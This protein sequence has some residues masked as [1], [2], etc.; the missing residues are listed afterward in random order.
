MCIG[1][2][3]CG[4]GAL[5]R[6]STALLHNHVK[7]VT[8]CNER[9]EKSRVTTSQGKDRMT[10]QTA[11]RPGRWSLGRWLTIAAALAMTT[12]W[13]AAD[14]FAADE[15]GVFSTS[16][17]TGNQLW[18]SEP[19]TITKTRL[20]AEGASSSYQAQVSPDS[21]RV[22]WVTA[23]G[24]GRS[25]AM[26]VRASD[27]KTAA[28]RVWATHTVGSVRYGM[29][30]HPTWSPDGAWLWYTAH[31]DGTTGTGTA[32]FKM[33]RDGTQRT[34]VVDWAND[35]SWPAISP[36]GR[37]IAFLSKTNPNGTLANNGDT[38][39]AIYTSDHLGQLFVANADGTAATQVTPPLSAYTR[40]NAIG[41]PAFSPDGTKIAFHAGYSGC[42]R[43]DYEIYTVPVTGAVDATPR[44]PR[45]AATSCTRPRAPAKRS[46]G[47][48]RTVRIR[49]R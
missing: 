25:D 39:G 13:P 14:A 42:C 15:I 30:S 49:G 21:E 8:L 24:T 6:S 4:R 28:T 22:V 26:Y 34:K 9:R 5:E 20:L 35:Q 48:R 38:T 31:P 33:R 40:H 29:V 27:A 47:P 7:E 32:I 43:A 37:K 2:A 1:A 41:A 16:A 44:G 45:T 36:D 10:H 11:R 12:A 46:S 23:P 3:T 18:A 19:G 17:S